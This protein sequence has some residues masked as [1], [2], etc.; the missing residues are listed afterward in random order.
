M[1]VNR[2]NIFSTCTMPVY[3]VAMLSGDDAKL[4]DKKVKAAT[5]S[6]RG[7][8]F[9]SFCNSCSSTFSSLTGD[10]CPFCGSTQTTLRSGNS[11]DSILTGLADMLAGKVGRVDTRGACIRIPD[12]WGM[13]AAA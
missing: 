13:G 12:T 11:S 3:E 2:T 1:V 9:F 8:K 5:T 7:S 10:V 4:Y 6:S